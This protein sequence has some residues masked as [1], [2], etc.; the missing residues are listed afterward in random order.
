MKA[1]EDRLWDGVILINMESRPERLQ[2]FQRLAE[3]TKLLNGWERLVAVDGLKVPGFG[4]RPFFRGGSRDRARAGRGGCVLSHRKALEKAMQEGWRAVLILE[5]DVTLADD[6]ESCALA[7][8]DT[9][10]GVA[11]WGVCYLGYTQ[12]VG[13]FQMVAQLDG[14]R[15][16][17]K[18]AG[19]Y[20]THA[21][22]V[23]QEVYETILRLLPDERSIW[24]WLLRHRAIDR[25]Y[26]RHLS[27]ECQV[28]AVTP[29]ICGQFSD[30][31][32]IGQRHAGA[33]R[34]AEF[35]VAIPPNRIMN[36]GLRYRA[37]LFR[38]SLKVS[39]EGVYD[40]A[41]ACWKRHFGA[42]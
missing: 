20:T 36:D 8:N 27:G 11:D 19:C 39:L 25:W 4:E 15:C 32:D 38:R 12:P 29:G 40:A 24:G 34:E 6:F 9:L 30:F 2:R 10:A 7:L 33:E 22:V 31:S 16:L 26:A 17:V 42:S 1:Q 18:V 5:D 21:Y 13:P 41:R 37:A 14:P 3:S 35:E 28:L 23:R